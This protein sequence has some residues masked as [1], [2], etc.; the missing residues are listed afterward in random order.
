MKLSVTDRDGENHE[1][2]GTAGYRLMEALRDLDYGV[3]AICG[4]MCSCATCHV[5]VDPEWLS[6]LPARADDESDLLDALDGKRDG[7]R[8]SCQIELTDDLDGLAVTIAPEE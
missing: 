4:G 6:K 7:S 5:Y 1:V 2:E 3:E 8:L